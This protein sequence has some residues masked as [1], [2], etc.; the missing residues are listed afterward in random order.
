MYSSIN[1][2]QRM[3]MHISAFVC[4]HSCMHLSPDV[5]QCKL[6]T[7]P[8]KLLPLY[9]QCYGARYLQPTACTMPQI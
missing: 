9:L 3:H 5:S 7:T 1:L 4:T 2:M 6:K 8:C